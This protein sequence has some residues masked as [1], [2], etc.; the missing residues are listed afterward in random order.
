MNFH[1]LSGLTFILGSSLG[2][3]AQNTTVHA[4]ACQHNYYFKMIDSKTLEPIIGTE[5]ALDAINAQSDINGIVM[6]RYPCNTP[7]HL[8]IIPI[9]YQKIDQNIQLA[10]QQDTIVYRLNP[11][12]NMIQGVEILGH[13]KVVNTTNA[14]Q[15][16]QNEEI[17]RLKGQSIASIASQIPGVTMLQTGA[18]IAKPMINGLS[19][20]RVI[21]MNNGV[22]QEG[23]QW[24]NEHAPEIDAQMASKITVIKGAEA[25]KYGAEAMGGI[26]LIDPADLHYDQKDSISGLIDLG[27]STNGQKGTL[28]AQLEGGIK[29]IDH[30][31]WRVQGSGDQ[32]G[33]YKTADYYLNNTG[34]KTLNYSATLGYDK[35]NFN[36][37]A[38]YSHYYN[39]GGIFSG[40]H[41]GNL[42]DLLAAIKNG[43][44]FTE[45][46]FSYEIAAPKQLVSHDLAKLKGHYHLNPNWQLNGQY[47]FQVDNRKEFDLRRG[48][49][50]DVPSLDLNLYV[51]QLDLNVEYLDGANWK[52]TLGLSGSSLVNNNVPGTFITP[53]IP[54]Y[55]KQVASLYFI[56]NYVHKDWSF[57]AGVRYDFTQLSAAGFNNQNQSIGG[58]HQY[59]NVSGS[60]G[61][62]YQM[63]NQF[64]F[65]SNLGTAFRPPSINELYSNGLHHGAAQIEVGDKNLQVERNLN[66]MNT[67]SFNTNDRKL[68]V[69]ANGYIN[70]IKNYIYLQPTLT[71]QNSL[72]GS[73]PIFDYK[74]TDARLIGGD[75]QATYQI[76]PNLQ[77]T[78]KGALIY[79]EDVTN[80]QYLPYIPSQRMT[81]KITYN[82]NKVSPNFSKSY[83]YIEN[84]TVAKQTRYEANSD[85]VSPP[86]GYSIWGAGLG[87]NFNIKNQ[88]FSLNLDITNLT[89]VAYKDY[90]N[91]FRYYAHDM[92]RNINLGLHW[93]F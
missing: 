87:T 5:F 38:Y 45:G 4:P 70:F 89:N 55:D 25:I 16:I 59:H 90:L 17:K 85:F 51:H 49:K 10:Q 83:V 1:K 34:S 53:L 23:Q 82:F 2:T 19:G 75:V 35:E 22:K 36:L 69:Y 44:P 14:Q 7:A 91:R 6:V 48:N 27:V 56:Q 65:Q 92:G 57:N 21:I 68:V 84:I 28:N 18:T 74:Q 40:A 42:N 58:E 33:N 62:N 20:N 9:G 31:R 93:N 11:I 13:K 29:N 32:S 66:W 73:F 3:Y 61:F 37:E 81:N 77:Y 54:N 15:T 30:L 63:N 78:F 80:K 71:Y 26:L 8:H 79:A 67:I 64:T 46:T 39:E 52:S 88:V 60:L 47:S 72:R 76:I 41:I 86:N 12:N 24:G 43:R 50:T